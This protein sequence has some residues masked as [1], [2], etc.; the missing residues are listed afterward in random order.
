[1]KTTCSTEQKSVS[2]EANHMLVCS[3]IGVQKWRHEQMLRARSLSFPTVRKYGPCGLQLKR[4]LPL[5]VEH[6]PVLRAHQ[7]GPATY[8]PPPPPQ[9]PLLVIAGNSVFGVI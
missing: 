2:D 7:E 6:E 3:P 9:I 1:M 4:H 8:P 5:W